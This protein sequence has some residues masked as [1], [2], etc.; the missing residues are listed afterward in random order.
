M[1]LGR[2]ELQRRILKVCGVLR[3]DI[4]QDLEGL[5]IVYWCQLKV[6]DKRGGMLGHDMTDGRTDDDTTGNQDIRTR[7]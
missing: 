6:N 5:S 3:I 7:P 1:S 2:V 4:S